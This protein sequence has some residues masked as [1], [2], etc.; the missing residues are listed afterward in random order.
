ML[1]GPLSGGLFHGELSMADTQEAPAVTPIDEISGSLR[2]AEQA[3]LG[4]IDSQE[5]PEAEE[6]TTDENL[7][8]TE[9]PDEESPAVSED[10][11]E[12]VEEDESDE[13][14]SEE[15]EEEEQEPVY[16]VRVDGEEIEVS[17]DELL[18]GYS[19]QSSFTKKS[20]QLAE[21]RKN[22]ESLNDQYNSE[23]TQ[24]Q[25][26]RQQYANYLQSIIENS[27]LDQWGAIDWEALKRDDPIEYVTKREELREHSEK[28]QRLQAEQKNAQQ[29]VHHSQ[30]QQWA[31]TVKTEHAALVEK[32][33]EWGKPE[34]QRELAGRLRDYAKVQGYQDEEIN[35]LVDHRSF[36]ILNKARLYD[37]LQQSDVKTKKLKNKP[38]VIRG[39]KGSSKK[40]ESKGKHTKLRNRLKQSGKVEHAADLLEDLLL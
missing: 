36:I 28:V 27:Q 15:P 8:S 14:E 7:E 18:S 35:S 5:Q 13:S 3:L 4:L 23:I 20:Q 24:I 26:E 31:D 32:L 34:S 38:R 12:E 11:T 40:S 33:P 22:F 9:Q 19:R 30:Q 2:G 6:A 29:K 10:E 39:G 16:A 25:Q 37:E 17:L 1:V 21:D